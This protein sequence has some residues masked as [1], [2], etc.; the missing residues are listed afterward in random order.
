MK[1]K[2]GVSSHVR[3]RVVMRTT[4]PF[5][6]DRTTQPFTWDRTTQH[7]IVRTTPSQIKPDYCPDI[8]STQLLGVGKCLGIITET[9]RDQED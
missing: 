4:Q 3:D 5:I 9:E 6:W 1:I 2:G 8:F 7:L